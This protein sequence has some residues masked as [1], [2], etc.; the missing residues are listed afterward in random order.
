MGGGSVKRFC[1][2]GGGGFGQLKKISKPTSTF[3]PTL[4]WSIKIL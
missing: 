4:I 2:G 3:L 1:S